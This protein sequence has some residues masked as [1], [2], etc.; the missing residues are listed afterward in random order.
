MH[1]R[2]KNNFDFVRF[3]A[4]TLVLISHSFALTGN[5]KAEPLAVLSGYR[6][7]LGHLAVIIFFIASGFLIAASWNNKPDFLRFI[8]SRILRIIPGLA[9]VLLFCIL[10]GSIITTVS[11]RTFYGS[12]I[13][14]FIRNLF[15]YKGQGDLA[16]VFQQNVYGDAVNGSLWTLRI[17]FTCYLLIAAIGMIGALN[18]KTAWVLWAITTV[19]AALNIHSPNLI[20][21]LLPLQA[22]FLAGTISY[23]HRDDAVNSTLVCGA[24][25]LLIGAYITDDILLISPAIA[26]ILIKAIYL[27]G[28]LNSFG[29]YGDFSY[30]IY[31][32]AFPIQ[33]FFVYAFP[34]IGWMENCILSF[35]MTLICA[36]ASWHCVEKRCLAFKNISVRQLIKRQLQ[37]GI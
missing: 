16:G 13:T 6:T 33:Q 21:E 20:K 2:D 19:L 4:A 29:K 24:A 8:N 27:R 26:F 32:Y 12:A 7:D 36:I 11:S 15:M 14:F 10:I 9:V 35:P 34:G 31:I 28:P 3:F 25:I 1:I 30:G 23:L 22:W 5:P 17:E 18:K 37:R